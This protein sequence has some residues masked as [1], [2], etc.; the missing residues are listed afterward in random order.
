VNGQRGDRY[1]GDHEDD[2]QNGDPLHRV[3]G[4]AWRRDRHGASALAAFAAFIIGLERHVLTGA[5]GVIVLIVRALVTRCALHHWRSCV[6]SRRLRFP[7]FWRARRPQG[8]RGGARRR[9]ARLAGDCRALDGAPWLAVGRRAGRLLK[10]RLE[11]RDGEVEGLI[12][13]VDVTLGNRRLHI[14]QL[15]EQSLARTLVD[16]A[17]GLGR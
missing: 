2:A 14:A 15:G 4:R 5:P 3:G 6:R 8:L 11:L 1:G 7:R 10:R 17:P 9:L 12:F 13:P 16:R